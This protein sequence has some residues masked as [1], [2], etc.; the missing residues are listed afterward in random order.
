MNNAP[1]WLRPQGV[2]AGKPST[3]PSFGSAPSVTPHAPQR[4]RD[5]HG[6]FS[7]PEG[8]T[9]HTCVLKSQDFGLTMLETV[10]YGSDKSRNLRVERPS[11]PRHAPAPTHPCTGPPA[12][13]SRRRAPPAGSGPKAIEHGRAGRSSADGRGDPGEREAVG[14]PALT[15]PAPT[16]PGDSGAA[17]SSQP[18]IGA[19]GFAPQKIWVPS[20]PMM[21]TETMLTTIDFAVAVPTPTGPPLAV[22]P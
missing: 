18:P 9:I 5:T 14:A 15:M 20:I 6:H 17:A 11:A 4:G 22:K 2:D 10:A 7:R 12:R 21:W 13:E 16:Y 19:R 8:A 1:T 3:G